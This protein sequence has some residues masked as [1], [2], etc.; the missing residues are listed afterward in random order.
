MH[1]CFW[2]GNNK[3]SIDFGKPNC[4]LLTSLKDCSSLEPS[5]YKFIQRLSTPGDTPWLIH[6]V[7]LY[8]GLGPNQ[9][10]WEVSGIHWGSEESSKWGRWGRSQVW[11]GA[12]PQMS[13][14]DIIW[15]GSSTEPWTEL[16]SKEIW[17]FNFSQ[18]E[19]GSPCQTW[20]EASAKAV[21]LAHW[22]GKLLGFPKPWSWSVP[23]NQSFWYAYLHYSPQPRN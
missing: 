19:V 10:G 5:L 16:R 21:F 13:P 22:K 18:Q 2:D 6:L 14:S 9:H 15:V 17:P 8:P 7:L 3:V 12:K 23:K 20:P 11:V 4:Q 1:G